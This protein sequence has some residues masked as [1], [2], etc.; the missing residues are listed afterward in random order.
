MFHSSKFPMILFLCAISPW[1]QRNEMATIM[2]AKLGHRGGGRKGEMG[3]GKMW[4]TSGQWT[5]VKREQS[6]Q[7]LHALCLLLGTRTCGAP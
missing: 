1:T 3:W 6:R 7:I 2:Q 4:G 5:L